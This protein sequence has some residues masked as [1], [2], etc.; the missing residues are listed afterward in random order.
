MPG[1]VGEI[2]M[3]T[4]LAAVTVNVSEPEILVA[5]SVAVIV[6]VPADAEV[7][8]PE[9]ILMVATLVAEDL[10]VTMLVMSCV[11]LSE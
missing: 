8:K 4:S 11:V 6:V 2:E 10:H 7:A 5:G 3:D 1:F 9:A